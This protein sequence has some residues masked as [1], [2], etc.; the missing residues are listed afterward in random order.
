MFLVREAPHI[1]PLVALPCAQQSAPLDGLFSRE[2]AA[3]PTRGIERCFTQRIESDLA[4]LAVVDVICA[5]VDFPSPR[6]LVRGVLVA[7]SELA[8]SVATWQHSDL[9][10]QLIASIDANAGEVNL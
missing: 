7:V 5:K 3:I 2:V 10:A 6:R 8:E 4:V 9:V 1:D